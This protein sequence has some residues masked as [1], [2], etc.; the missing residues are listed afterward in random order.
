[1]LVSGYRAGYTREGFCCRSDYIVLPSAL[2]AGGAVYISVTYF[3][4]LRT[5][6]MQFYSSV[7]VILAAPLVAGLNISTND[8]GQ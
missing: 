3:L 6:T 5:A 7:L 8:A 4:L 1:M 2:K